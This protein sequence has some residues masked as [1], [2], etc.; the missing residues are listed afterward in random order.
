M[1]EDIK[2][3]TSKLK[4]QPGASQATIKKVESKYNFEFPNDYKEFLLKSN[5]ASGF[6]GK[7]YLLI[8]PL[9]DIEE[10]NR[11]AKVDEFTPGLVLFGSDGSGMSYAFDVRRS[12]PAFVE[13]PDMSIH[14]KEI[15][16]CGSTFYEFLKYLFNKDC[17]L[18]GRS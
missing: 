4:F 9:E 3:L 13:I 14:I 2:K 11:L 12:P 15:K 1:S 10:I 17:S 7:S 5:G 6:V 8:W 16:T 18:S